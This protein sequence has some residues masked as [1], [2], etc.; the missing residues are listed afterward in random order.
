MR[1]LVI[2]IRRARLSDAEGLSIVHDAAWREAY[3]GVLPGVAL[4]RMIA[5]R[6]PDWWRQNATRGHEPGNRQM[7][8]LEVGDQVG[9]YV[10][11]GPNRMLSLPQ[12][13]EIDALYLDPV[14]Q[15]LGLG[16]RL[17]RAA[18]RDLSGRSLGSTVIWC[19]DANTRGSQFYAGLGGVL[20]TRADFRI[21][22]VDFPA[23]AWAFS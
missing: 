10:I 17:F 22:G 14:C 13:G 6:G 7:L 18:R 20:H 15:G 12:R 16:R 9:G 23:S 2:S 4:E 3:Q 11:Y 1:E 19:L 8:V 5:R 21:G